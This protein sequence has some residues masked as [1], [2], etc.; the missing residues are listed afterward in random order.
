MAKIIKEGRIPATPHTEFYSE[1]G[2]LALEEI[3]GTLGF[4]GPWSRKL[5]YRYYPTEQVQEPFLADFSFEA[6][7]PQG[8]TVL[9]PQIIQTEE[10]PFQFDALKGRSLLLNGPDT[11]VSVLKSRESFPKDVFFRNADRHEIFFVQNGTGVF[12]TEF[13]ELPF[14]EGHYVI[15]PKGVTYRIDL[16]SSE[17]FLLLIES[18]FP[19]EWPEHYMNQ[20]GQ[21]HMM[22]PIV[23]TEITTPELKT[24]I[25]REGEYP[26]FIKHNG[27][28]V[29]QVTLGHH[30]FDVIGWEGALYPFIFDINDHHGIAREIHAAPPMHQTFQ[31]GQA[32]YCGFSICSFVPQ[33]EGWH[34]KEVPAP[35]AHYNV[36]SDEVMFFSNAN[37]GARK[38]IISNASLTFH[39]GST[40]H[41]PHGQA[42]L[43][44][45]DQ[46]GK[47]S[48]RLAVMMD[49]FFE[50]L[51]MTE[52]AYK[53]AD[54]S[55]ALSWDRKNFPQK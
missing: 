54:K 2:V 26:I 7:V 44:S 47:M 40:P 46:R 28:R 25:D 13:G 35:Y 22:A 52:E 10:I 3:H 36:D 11:G 37:Y 4:G 32:P 24:P 20:G 18:K 29:T 30:P 8:G 41:S 38:G 27:G 14:K 9:S 17:L 43:K 48:Q 55:Y 12:S 45:L 49:T 53:Y 33:P 15:V 31:A 50:S 1:E 42:A 6:K 5:H 16:T 23:E 51:E 21:A 19:I 39:P 34:E